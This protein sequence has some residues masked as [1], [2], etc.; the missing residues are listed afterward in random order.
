MQCINAGAG[1]SKGKPYVFFQ[2]VV[3]N[4]TKYL[5]ISDMFWGATPD[6]AIVKFDKSI[7]ELMKGMYSTQKFAM[8]ADDG[9]TVN[10]IGVSFI[11]DGG[12]TQYKHLIP[13]YKW[14]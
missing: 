2:C 13:P 6:A 9:K 7:K 12:Y 8:Y 5:S 14:M 4:T 11:C 10:E 3:S 1:D